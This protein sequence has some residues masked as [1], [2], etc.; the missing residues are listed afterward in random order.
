MHPGLNGQLRPVTARTIRTWIA[1]YE[2]RGVIGLVR[3]ARSDR[4]EQRNLIS[5]PWDRG[6][7]FDDATKKR[8]AGELCRKVRSLWASGALGW[9]HVQRMAT[10]NLVRRTRAADIDLSPTE[11]LKV[12]TVPCGFVERERR[13]AQVAVHDKDAKRFFDKHTR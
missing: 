5:R 4:D 1:A 10:A 3:K 9:R 12:C 8:I 2:S 11:L 6:V 7:P 13:Y